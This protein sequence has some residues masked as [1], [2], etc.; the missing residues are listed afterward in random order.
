[1][2]AAVPT[3]ECVELTINEIKVRNRQ[4]RKIPLVVGPIAPEKNTKA[5][6]AVTRARKK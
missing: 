2:G 4:P 6:S 3:R 1:M 5:A